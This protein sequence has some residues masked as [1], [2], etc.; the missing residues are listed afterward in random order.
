MMPVKEVLQRDSTI[1]VLGFICTLYRVDC[2]FVI[3]FSNEIRFSFGS[4]RLNFT[5]LLFYTDFLF[6]QSITF[7]FAES[8]LSFFRAI[9]NWLFR[10]FLSLNMYSFYSLKY[11]YSHSSYFKCL[12]V[13]EEKIPPIHKYKKSILRLY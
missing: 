4:L 6:I 13:K 9:I 7:W 8:K 2:F 1:S 10:I 11:P 5:L 12:K 3:D